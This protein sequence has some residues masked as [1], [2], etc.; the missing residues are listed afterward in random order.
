[1]KILLAEDEAVSRRL[2][3]GRLRRA[4]HSVIDVADGGQAFRALCEENAPSM[5]VLDWMMP[6]M[7]GIEICRA[8]RERHDHPYVYVI[9]VTSRTEKSD[10]IAGLDAGADDFLAKPY[11]FEELLSRLRV[12]ERILGLEQGLAAKV[13]ELRSALD[14]VKLLQGFLPICMHCKR[15][16]DTTNNWQQVEAYIEA[17]SEAVFS[18][19]LCHQCLEEHYPE[20]AAEEAAE[21]AAEEAAAGGE[22][23][24]A[25]V[26]AR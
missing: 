14:Q 23:P 11:D 7:E 22:P 10:V 20:T 17:H 1:L 24:L 3:A 9:M 6:G 25:K 4:G 16:R 12:G 2:L 13:R 8:L 5:A 18:H 15:V 19:G 21:R 26:T